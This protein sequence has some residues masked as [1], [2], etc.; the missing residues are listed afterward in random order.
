MPLSVFLD[1]NILRHSEPW[2]LVRIQGH[3]AQ[4]STLTVPPFGSVPGVEPR[5]P[6]K[7][8]ESWL[9]SELNLLSQ[10]GPAARRGEIE[11]F[12]NELVRSELSEQVRGRRATGMLGYLQDVRIEKVPPPLSVPTEVLEGGLSWKEQKK[13]WVKWLH[14]C[15]DP[16]YAELRSA[17]PGTHADNTLLD[18]YHVYSAEKARLD[19]F[20]TLDKHSLAEPLREQKRVKLCIEILYP[21]EL[22]ARLG[23]LPA[24]REE[25]DA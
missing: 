17:L 5:P 10:I 8:S 7:P 14:S 9:R 11:C 2:R 16:R 24:K 19:C 13:R 1:A 20:L 12:D 23:I 6:R 3:P 22:L 25:R 15:S 18:L 21:S 4:A